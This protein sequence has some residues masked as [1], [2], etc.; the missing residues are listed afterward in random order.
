MG[1]VQKGE[2]CSFLYTRALGNR[3]TTAEEVVNAEGIW[4]QT[5]R[6]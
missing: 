1:L 4:P 2:S 3:E 5:S 6:E